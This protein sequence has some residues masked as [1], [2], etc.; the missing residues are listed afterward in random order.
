MIGKGNRST[1]KKPS[2]VPLCPPKTPHACPD[3]NPGRRGVT[4]ATNRLSYGTASCSC[5]S[6]LD[7]RASA[8]RFVSL[9]ILNLIQ[10]VGIF[11]RG[12]SP[13]QGRYLHTGQQKRR[14]NAHRHPCLK[15]HS[16]PRSQ[17][18]KAQR[19]FIP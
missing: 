18:L 14:I 6:H 4:P 11:G 2:P 1:R 8:K 9:Q 16:N 12:I 3:A 5:Y 15:W 10:S 7:H 13:M 17:C 19:Y